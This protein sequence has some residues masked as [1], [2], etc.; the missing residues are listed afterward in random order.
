[1]GHQPV[2]EPATMLLLGTG[3]LGIAGVGRKKLFKK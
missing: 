2:P 1:M 3:L